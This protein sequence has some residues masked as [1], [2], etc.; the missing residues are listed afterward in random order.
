MASMNGGGTATTVS[1][2]FSVFWLHAAAQGSVW[3][4]A[5]VPQL[6]S[7][8]K[9]AG[10]T[11]STDPYTASCSVPTHTSIHWQ[12]GTQADHGDVQWA[13]S[14]RVLYTTTGTTASTILWGPSPSDNA[15]SFTARLRSCPYGNASVEADSYTRQDSS[16][17]RRREQMFN[18]SASPPSQAVNSYQRTID[19]YQRSASPVRALAHSPSHSPPYS[20]PQSPTRNLQSAFSPIEVPSLPLST[21]ENVV[22]VVA[23]MPVHQ[24]DTR[25]S[26]IN[27]ST[28][29]KTPEAQEAASPSSFR[30]E[31]TSTT[32]VTTDYSTSD[33]SPAYE[34][35]CD[36]VVSAKGI[37][38]DSGWSAA[39]SEPGSK[40]PT[41]RRVKRT[42]KARPTKQ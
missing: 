30:L 9:L 29:I 24:E 20:P 16:S 27:S 26:E 7:G 28:V 19:S 15:R 21:V 25:T 35:P 32:Q 4:R 33:A 31:E 8:V 37:I 1:V 13:K 17:P 40:E 34:P 10:P 18:R 42:R 6:E 5:D 38:G 2:K 14:A 12:A 39:V 22:E 3:I 41:T 23:P 11:G 36:P